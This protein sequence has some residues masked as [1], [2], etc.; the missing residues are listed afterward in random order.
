VKVLRNR[1]GAGGVTLI[2]LVVVMAIIAIMGAFMAPAIGEWVDNYRIRQTARDIVSTLQLAK[3]RAISTHVDYRVVFTVANE[4]YRLERNDPSTGWSL[5]GSDLNAAR[6]VD[7]DNTNFTS[8]IV[9]FNPSGTSSSGSIF[10]DN[11][12]GKQYQVVVSPTGR[13]RIQESW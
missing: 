4:N 11:V 3:I 9:R 2:E 6:G 5:E 8:D 1:L 13:I 12:K 10:I 7:I